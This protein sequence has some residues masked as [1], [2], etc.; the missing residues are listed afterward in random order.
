[1]AVIGWLGLGHA[2]GD[3]DDD[4]DDYHGGSDGD[5]KCGGVRAGVRVVRGVGLCARALADYG[6]LLCMCADRPPSVE[7][8][9]T[10]S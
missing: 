3:G 5:G 4:V 1:M 2:R 10:T 7:L 9:E 6:S 8:W